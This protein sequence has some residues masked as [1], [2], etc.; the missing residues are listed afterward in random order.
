VNLHIVLTI[1]AYLAMFVL[2]GLA[3]RSTLSERTDRQHANRDLG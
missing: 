3:L 2:A 1:L